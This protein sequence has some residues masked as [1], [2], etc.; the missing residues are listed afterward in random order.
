MRWRF[1]GDPAGKAMFVGPSCQICAD[2][3]FSG[4]VKTPTFDSL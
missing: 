2:T 3:A 4:F 1:M